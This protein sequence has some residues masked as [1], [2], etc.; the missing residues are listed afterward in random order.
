MVKARGAGVAVLALGVLLGCGGE[1]VE[2]D[3]PP[4]C[5]HGVGPLAD[6][7]CIDPGLGPD[8]CAPGFSHDGDRGCLPILPEP[9]PLGLMAVPG[10][11]SCREVAPCGEGRWGGIPVE[12]TTEHVDAGYAGS[13]SDGSAERP[14]L[15]IQD[16]VEAAA[17]GAIVAV[18]AGSYAEDVEVSGKPVRLWGRCPALVELVGTGAE[19]G[20]LRVF[21]GGSGTEVR[22]LAITS[23]VAGVIVS[24]AVGVL[25]ESLWVHDTG[26]IG[27]DAEGALGPTGVLVRGTLVERTARYGVMALGTEVAL[28]ASVVR[29]TALH[30]TLGMGCGAVAFIGDGDVPARLDVTGSVIERNQYLG[31]AARDGELRVE[32][33]VVRD[34]AVDP[35]DL[36]GGIGISTETASSL[37]SLTGSL[38]ER[39]PH[40][41]VFTEGGTVSIER[42]VLRD[43]QAS[44]VGG[45]YAVFAEP[46]KTTG[47]RASVGIVSSLIER[48]QGVSVKAMGSDLVVEATVIRDTELSSGSVLELA[49]VGLAAM[50]SAPQAVPAS[51]VLRRSLVE[52]NRQIGVFVG[53][54]PATIES[55]LIR[56][57][58]SDDH[59]F[60][61]GIMVLGFDDFAAEA[62]VSNTRIEDNARAALIL[63]GAS[64]IAERLRGL[65]NPV[66]IDGEGYAGRDFSV[67]DQGDNRCGCPEPTGP[68]T[69]VTLGFQP[70]T[71]R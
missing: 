8:D 45:G 24:G 58:G 19:V 48:N 30:P 5:D 49:G 52:R 47:E 39:N 29:D 38:V 59:G 63:F 1:T 12:P 64:L 17:P 14:W 10:D 67:D 66:D 35:S 55:S 27:I 18:A 70:D 56:Q 65:C 6:G 2:P 4:A 20:N 61:E 32:A 15:R 46:S 21:E 42:S 40:V 62:T 71:G 26:D 68:C 28:E 36:G 23:G 13:D 33:S 51:L 34:T 60:G 54:A 22:G 37:L 69:V 41:G 11:V 16:G 57:T 50:A 25:L 43:N 7:Q 31:L 44:V 3:P 9:C 53:G